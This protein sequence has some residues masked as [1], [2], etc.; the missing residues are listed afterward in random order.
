MFFGKITLHLVFFLHQGTKYRELFP[1]AY[2]FYDNKYLGFALI[3]MSN[4]RVNFGA[5][6]E[7]V[8]VVGS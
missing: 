2:A 4:V 3:F 5:N 6:S 8:L 1:I 7:G